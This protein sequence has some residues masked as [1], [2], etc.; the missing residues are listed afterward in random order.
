MLQKLSTMKGKALLLFFVFVAFSLYVTDAQVPESVIQKFEKENLQSLNVNW[1]VD[2]TNF[3]VTYNDTLNLHYRN[4]YDKNG[5]LIMR[6]SEIW[7][8][9]VLPAISSYCVAYLPSSEIGRVWLLELSETE[10][11]YYTI[12]DDVALFFDEEGNIFKWEGRPG[13]ALQQQ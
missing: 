4:V 11:S 9:N 7:K 6:E 2:G 10:R 12:V 8:N 5:N 3:I 13:L 1:K